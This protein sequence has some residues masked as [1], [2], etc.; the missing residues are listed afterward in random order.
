M[1]N[2]EF[3]LMQLNL[4]F[5]MGP[6][7]VLIK[8][9]VRKKRLGLVSTTAIRNKERTSF[10]LFLKDGSISGIFPHRMFLM[11]TLLPIEIEIFI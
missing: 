11:S 5:L 10:W 6:I 2:L 4:D 3:K 7:T 1:A 8:V 9:M